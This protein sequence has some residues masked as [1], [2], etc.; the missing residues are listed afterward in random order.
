MP[1]GKGPAVGTVEAEST[2][3][4]CEEAENRQG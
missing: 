3:T 2:E 1:E 4:K